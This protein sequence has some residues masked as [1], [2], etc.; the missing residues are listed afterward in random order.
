MFPCLARLPNIKD[1]PVRP[2][3]PLHNTLAPLNEYAH[4]NLCQNRVPKSLNWLVGLMGVENGL[5]GVADDQG[6]HRRK[7]SGERRSA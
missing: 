6:G 2:C 3:Q 5:R 4:G 7:R 1:C